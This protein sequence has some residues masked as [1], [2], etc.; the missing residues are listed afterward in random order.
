MTKV[1]VNGATG[2]AVVSDFPL[3][4]DGGG[5]TSGDE[6]AFSAG[7][8]TVSETE[9]PGY[10][11]A[12]TGDC[13]ADGSITLALGD[14]KSCTITNTERGTIIIEKATDPTGG[15]SFGFTDDIESP[16][17][18]SL[19]D[20]QSKTFTNVLP[21]TYTVTEDDPTPGFDL[22]GLSCVDTDTGGTD[23]TTD[24]GDREATINL[25]PGETV[26]CTFT[27][28]ER[29]SIQIIKDADPDDAQGGM[30]GFS[31][32]STPSRS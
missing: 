19:D 9:D 21:G 5:V 7:A 29:G 6:N 14:V 3:F 28:T 30:R 24:L 1:V 23:S 8:H 4:V 13:A 17:S 20:G 2:T 18:F 15:T 31:S 22:T 25:D 12:I 32:S 26:T 10:S 11:A 27:N 16:N